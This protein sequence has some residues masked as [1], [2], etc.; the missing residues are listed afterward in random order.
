MIFT[1]AGCGVPRILFREHEVVTCRTS[2]SRCPQQAWLHRLRV[3]WFI[4]FVAVLYQQITLETKIQS[5]L[6]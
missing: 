2:Q 1:L 5:N 3:T 4:L 6:H